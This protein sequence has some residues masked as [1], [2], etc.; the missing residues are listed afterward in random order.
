METPSKEVIEDTKKVW[1]H[2]YK[3]P[4]TDE[5]AIEIYNNLINFFSLL[6]EWDIEKK[7]QERLKKDEQN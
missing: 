1:Q 7:K 2:Y 3:D 4:L 6:I 5:D